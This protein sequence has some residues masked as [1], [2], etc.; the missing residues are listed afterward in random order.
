MSAVIE[1]H[2]KENYQRLMK[3][4][5]FRCGTQWDA[6]DVLQEAYARCL[7]YFKPE[8]VKN[9]NNWFTSV[10]NNTIRDHKAADRGSLVVSFEEEEVE[11]LPC[12]QYPDR[13]SIE[14]AALINSKPKQ[15]AEVL[16]LYFQQGYTAKDI[17]QVVENI[18][19][20]AAHQMITRFKKELKEL[21]G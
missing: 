16:N 6:E 7:K 14:I 13:V 15:Q 5:T 9:F 10:L 21:Y 8:Y 2:Y 17:G 11:G 12:T 3:R 20:A 4:L 1:A 19:Y 18:S